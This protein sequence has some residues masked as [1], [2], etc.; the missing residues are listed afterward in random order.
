MRSCTLPQSIKIVSKPPHRRRRLL[1]LGDGHLHLHASYTLGYTRQ[2]AQHLRAMQSKS[3]SKP[4]PLVLAVAATSSLS[5]TRRS[6][7]PACRAAN[8]DTLVNKATNESSAML[9]C[10]VL[11]CAVLYCAVLCCAMPPRVGAPCWCPRIAAYHDFSFAIFPCWCP[12]NSASPFATLALSGVTALLVSVQYSRAG[13]HA[14][15]LPHSQLARSTF[16]I[17]VLVPSQR[18]FLHLHTHRSIF[19]CWCPRIAASSRAQR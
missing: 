13:A 4:H 2:T 12:R 19:P 15:Q 3:Q 1:A 9:C 7:S 10:T 16:N 17:P 18:S 8:S 6:H 5:C 14:T 11:C